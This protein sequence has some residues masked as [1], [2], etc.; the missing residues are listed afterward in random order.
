MIAASMP[1]P[2]V[3]VFVLVITVFL[4]LTGRPIIKAL[5][6]PLRKLFGVFRRVILK[7][8]HWTFR[9]ILRAIRRGL[10]LA[11]Q[12]ATPA[13]RATAIQIGAAPYAALANVLEM[14]SAA[15]TALGEVPASVK[16]LVQRQGLF[17]RSA[18]A[19]KAVEV[20]HNSLSMED[21]NRNV[22]SAKNYY[23][24]KIERDASPGLLYENSEEALIIGILKDVDLTFFYVLRR[25]N[26]NVTRNILKV[27]AVMTAIVVIFPFVISTIN[28]SVP[29]TQYSFY[30]LLYF[31]TC[32]AFL[33]FLGGTRLFYSIST[34]NNGQHFNYF[35]QTY[36]SRMLNQYK[37]AAT[38]FANVLNNRTTSLEETKSNSNIWFL[39]LHWLSARQWFLE[40]YFR[41]IV[42]QIGRNL[43]LIYLTMSVFALVVVPVMYFE[44]PHVIMLAAKFVLGILGG[45]QSLTDQ[46]INWKL[47]WNL[48][49]VIVP[50]AILFGLYIWALTGLL[51]NF[52]REITADGGFDFRSMD[53]KDAIE[54]YIGPIV[55]E[56]VERRRNPYGQQ[57]ILAPPRQ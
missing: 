28:L 33:A 49:T 40:L 26:R 9:P 5:F 15:E 53:M 14:K 57:P 44:L 12:T 34:R 35:V 21:A 50:T 19:N 7:V 54:T 16:A 18:N 32:A 31:V 41:N 52:W 27:M 37:S 1:G 4:L 36:F 46:S 23:E 20:L 11:S 43:W 24:K 22:K 10:G 55:R 42:F 25:I 47:N 29:G 6:N 8:Y 48:R 13:E 2:L 30:V 17:F 3:F 38:E 51:S 45:G 39:N 56:V